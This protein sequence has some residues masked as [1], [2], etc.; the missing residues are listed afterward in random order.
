MLSSLSHCSDID[1]TQG[2]ESV[3]Y[4]EIE[5]SNLQLRT[6]QKITLREELAGGRQEIDLRSKSIYNVRV[7]LF[8]TQAG[9]PQELTYLVESS[10]GSYQFFY[11]QSPGLDLIFSYNDSDPASNPIGLSC[12]ITTGGAVDGSISM[13]LRRGLDKQASGV[14]FGDDTHARGRIVLE[15]AFHV[16]V[17]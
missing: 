7:R 12:T 17:T 4:A 8:T 16:S 5:V 6:V 11:S 3:E 10:A 1:E 14:R 2:I 9:S 15:R 13:T